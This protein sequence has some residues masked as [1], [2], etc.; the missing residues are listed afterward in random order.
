MILLNS[1][2]EASSTND[3]SMVDPHRDPLGPI[4]GGVI[5]L[6]APLK[7]QALCHVDKL[8]I[9]FVISLHA[10]LKQQALCHADKLPIL[11]VISL[12]APLKQQ[13]LCHAD[14]LPI[15]FVDV[16]SQGGQHPP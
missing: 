13:T 9:L 5:S 15:L 16:K 12:H 6:H 1:H 2:V 14:K 7:Q 3:R 10:P 4:S 8:P 11:F